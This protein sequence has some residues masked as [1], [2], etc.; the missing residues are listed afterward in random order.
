MNLIGIRLGYALGALGWL[1][2]FYAAARIGR[3]NGTGAVNTV[4]LNILICLLGSIIGWW[5]G[6]LLSPDPTER[7]NFMDFRKA[8]SAFLS[9]FV[10]AKVDILFQGAVSQ[11]LTDSPLF[12][13]RIALFTT[14]AL[15]CAQ[16]TYVARHD[17]GMYGVR[18][19]AGQPHG[20]PPTDSDKNA[21]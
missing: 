16:F 15:I 2:C 9:G 14:T 11:N 1:A 4:W 21:T 3:D 20:A 10:L 18:Y 19:A 12:M 13:G 7:G 8:L 6:I 17:L 5:L